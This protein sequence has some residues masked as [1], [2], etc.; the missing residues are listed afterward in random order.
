MKPF[1]T[2]DDLLNCEK[3]HHSSTRYAFRCEAIRWSTEY[4]N[5]IEVKGSKTKIK[6]ID[7]NDWVLPG[8]S[9]TGGM[10]TKLLSRPD[11]IHAVLRT[12]DSY[13]INNGISK[14][15]TQHSVTIVSGLTKL[16]EYG[17][18]NGLYTID[19]WRTTDF[20]ALG[21][22][23]SKGGWTKAL[24]IHVRIEKGVANRPAGL[25]RHLD[26][27]F[28]HVGTNVNKGD[29]RK[30]F[31]IKRE[32]DKRTRVS[33]SV[34]RVEAL[35]EKGVGAAGL[36]AYF[37]LF[38]NFC[39]ANGKERPFAAASATAEELAG[40]AD[41]RTASLSPDHL[42][43]VMSNSLT[44][45]NAVAEPLLEAFRFLLDWR[46]SKPY[47]DV[48]PLDAWQNAFSMSVARNALETVVKKPI[49][50]D[51]SAK[52][53]GVNLYG[54]VTAFHTACFKMLAFMNSRRKDE[55][56][57]D[58]FGLQK[59]SLSL[60]DEIL[61]LF[62][63]SF[64]LEKTYRK[65]VNFY[66][67]DITVNIIRYLT[68]LSALALRFEEVNEVSKK[69]PDESRNSIFLLPDVRNQHGSGN[70]IRWYQ[71]LNPSDSSA[72]SYANE[73][74][75]GSVGH[76]GSHVNRR[77]Y[78]LLF[79]Y[80][81]ENGIMAALTQQFGHLCSG[82]TERYLTFMEDDKASLEEWG[83][84][85][86]GDRSALRED[87]LEREKEISKVSS[88]KLYELIVGV[89][90]GEQAAGGHFSRLVKR[91]AHA[92]AGEA[93]YS[94]LDLRATAKIAANYLIAKGHSHFP[95]K[96]AGCWRGTSQSKHRGQC[97]T[98]GERFA[99]HARA[100]AEK[101]DKCS[102]GHAIAQHTNNL[103]DDAELIERNIRALPNGSILENSMRSELS[104][105][106]RVIH[107]REERADALQI[108]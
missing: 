81:Y 102:Y 56:C 76:T 34:W 68:D 18:L 100:T 46:A 9:F 24:N 70:Q 31:S 67:N 85:S 97:Q 17:W 19:D 5:A 54:V 89:L 48:I 11:L 60:A 8:T 35:G 92:L 29:L 22:V 93:E 57:H 86:I 74:L 21:V 103:R 62:K 43:Q 99:N 94:H 82:S 59:D 50:I 27:V 105:T 95:H 96:H 47:S 13:I 71:Y 1:K 107:L 101:C 4:L 77:A 84:L 28:S 44:Y 15:T 106:R 79:H 14:S 98:K 49:S 23:L 64:Y 53:I 42:A 72:W 55:T 26:D 90:S 16:I 87:L 58:E 40:S 80:R 41:G 73:I 52:E 3:L 75:N 37:S 66:V 78:A 2:Q 10:P 61:G 45:I 7:L 6:T 108:S 30:T 104:V 63:V 38:N 12:L 83:D 51:Y 39:D 69:L 20:E 91:Y 25:L 88:E 36:V 65:R 32:G 33:D